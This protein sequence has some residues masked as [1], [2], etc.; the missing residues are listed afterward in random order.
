MATSEP[1]LA[2]R[3]QPLSSYRSRPDDEPAYRLLPFNFARFDEQRYLLSNDAGEYYLLAR[4]DLVAAV[5]GRLNP[6]SETYRDLRARHFLYDDHSDAALDL[7]ALKVR[8]KHARIRDFTGL[9]IFVVTLRCD[10]SCPYCQVSRQSE[11]QSAYDMDEATALTALEYVFKSPSPTVKIEFQGGEPLLNFPLIRFIV[12]RA[13]RLNQAEKRDLA[14]VIAS[15]LSFIDGEILDY[16]EAHGIGFSTSLDGPAHLHDANRPRPGRDGHRRTREGIRRVR[17]RLGPDRVSALMTTTAASLAEPRAI[18][19]E[20]IDAG[21]HSVFLRPLSPYGFAV[22]TRQTEKYDFERFLRFYREG[23]DYILALNR[24]GWPFVEHYSALML[25]KLLSVQPT[26]YVDLQSPAGAAI[27]ALV[28]NYDGGVYASDE[29]RMLAEMGDET[30]R[31]GDV[32]KDSYEQILLNPTLHA[33]LEES[34]T[35]GAPECYQCAFQPFC[36]S[37][38]VYHHATQ[39][40]WV[41]H[42]AFS[43]FCA[44][45][46]QVTSYLIHKLE[47]EP[48]D[49]EI[50]LD[51]VRP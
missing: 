27:S 22:K 42:K 44:R 50:L 25:T 13:E 39:G 14:F 19:D 29:G 33:V 41:G 21:F 36:G 16:C 10:Y 4:T 49:R 47:D 31:L 45:T 3:F 7:L 18:I 5:D 37:D 30:F 48:A 20:Y 38:P 40:D 2:K 6:D 24:N 12:E 9:H 15:N 46:Q 26:R 28:Y 17:E 43:A 34:L 23:M 51:W 32:H 11:D 8:T 35:Y 1:A